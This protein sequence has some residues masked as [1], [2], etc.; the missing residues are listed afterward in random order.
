MVR[1]IQIHNLLRTYNKQLKRNKANLTV[2]HKTQQLPTKDNID[3]SNVSQTLNK[4]AKQQ[5]LS[6]N[7]KA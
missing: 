5:N 4:V 6:I 3:I 7:V 2:E 1:A